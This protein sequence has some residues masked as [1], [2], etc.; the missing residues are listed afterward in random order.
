MISRYDAIVLAGGRA[1]RMSGVA[2][3]Q[4]LVGASTMLERVLS[5]VA[6]ADVRIVVGPSQSIPEDVLV[7]QEQ[8]PGSGPVAGVAAGLAHV[9]SPVVLVL[10]ADLPFLDPETIGSLL[11][12][13]DSNDSSDDG[14]GEPDSGDLAMLVDES[15][16]DQYLLAAWRTAALRMALAELAPFHGRS[17]RELV[18]SVRVHRIAAV[19]RPGA[20]NPWADVDTAEELERARRARQ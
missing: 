16:R 5:A 9:G 4:Q 13:L 12:G 1:T 6:A 14:S 17:M 10:A 19:P 8:P 11:A 20:P 15:G 3:P 18:N 7:V 2:K